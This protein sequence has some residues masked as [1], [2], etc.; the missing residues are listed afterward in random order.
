MKYIKI[1]L[2]LKKNLANIITISRIV[3]T[4]VLLPLKTLSNAFYAVYTY[5][6]ISD[7]LD[8]LVARKLK[9]FSEFGSKLDS[10][11]DISFYTVMMIKILPYLKR[12]LPKYVWWL[13]YFVL[14]IRF[15]CYVYFQVTRNEFESRHTIYNKITGLALFLIPFLLNSKYFI[16]YALFVLLIGYVS[17]IDELLYIIKINKKA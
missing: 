9:I 7:V 14:F 2:V 4:L 3:G 15:L 16:Y 12:S 1:Y 13:I 11:S 8:G 6:G 5:C 17:T 10:I